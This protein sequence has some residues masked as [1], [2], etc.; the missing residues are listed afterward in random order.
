M[1]IGILTTIFALVSFLLPSYFSLAQNIEG[2]TAETRNIRKIIGENTPEFITKSVV[3]IIEKTE[4]F[5]LSVYEFSEN[6]KGGWFFTGVSFLF[7]KKIFFYGV[8]LVILFWI[9][10]AIWR[11][12]F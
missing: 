10:R 2:E 3:L 9:A 1:R 11:R 7:G 8:T 4:G 12:I 6:K 5:R